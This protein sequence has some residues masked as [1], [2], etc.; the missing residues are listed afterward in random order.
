MIFEERVIYEIKRENFFKLRRNKF[1]EVCDRV[2]ALEKKLI[3]E[4]HEREFV[5]LACI[6]LI[7]IHDKR[8]K[9]SLIT[10]GILSNFLQGSIETL[11]PGLG[12]YFKKMMARYIFKKLG[13]NPNSPI[14]S[15]F[16]NVIKNFEFQALFR[17]F[18]TGNCPLIVQTLCKSLIDELLD[19]I[20]EKLFTG[21]AKQGMEMG[22]EYGSI[23][24]STGDFIK[25]S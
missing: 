5:N 21:M 16:I 18:Q 15:F 6:K 10:E 8:Y 25:E 3:N 14:G 7:E 23:D 19:Y 12:D 17:Y 11:V 20:K 24:S 1:L 13:I 4:G 9:K 2:V 22:S